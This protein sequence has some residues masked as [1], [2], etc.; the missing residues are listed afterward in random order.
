MEG[1][2]GTVQSNRG[3]GVYVPQ[4]V[5]NPLEM[6]RFNAVDRCS[7]EIR[8]EKNT[9]ALVRECKRARNRGRTQSVIRGKSDI[10]SI[11]MGGGN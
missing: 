9:I 6:V 8:K 2:R 7:E 1:G 10:V 4:D 3:G 5:L 11:H